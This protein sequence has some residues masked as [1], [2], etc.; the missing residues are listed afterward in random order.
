MDGVGSFA[1]DARGEDATSS[2]TSYSRG[3]VLVVMATRHRPSE[4]FHEGGF[5]LDRPRLNQGDII[6]EYYFTE[7][8]AFDTQLRRSIC[9][10]KHLEVED[11]TDLYEKLIAQAGSPMNQWRLAVGG[12]L[13]QNKMRKK[14]VLR[15]G[16]L[17]KNFK[18]FS[19]LHFFIPSLSL[20]VYSSRASGFPPFIFPFVFTAK[21][22]TSLLENKI[23][24]PWFW[25]IFLFLLVVLW[26]SLMLQG[27]KGILLLT[28][29][30]WKL[31]VKK[32]KTLAARIKRLKLVLKNL[33]QIDQQAGLC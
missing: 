20:L 10:F 5:P 12:F 31:P 4:S 2:G 23:C 15:I 13:I 24:Q 33:H 14:M 1:P 29:K 27:K 16:W 28:L 17:L 7:C 26:F 22:L 9:L 18:D 8:E 6:K 3:F 19:S 21:E 11:E 32:Q 30:A 25:V